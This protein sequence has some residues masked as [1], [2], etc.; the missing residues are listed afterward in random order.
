MNDNN[1]FIITV[2]KRIYAESLPVLDVEEKASLLIKACEKV[3]KTRVSRGLPL[4]SGATYK[5][6]ESEL[7][8]I[9]AA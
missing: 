1:E 2:Y 7:E 8:T 9:E 6:L 4:F 5:L 3:E